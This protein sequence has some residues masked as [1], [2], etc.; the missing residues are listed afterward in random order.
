[1]PRFERNAWSLPN[2]RLALVLVT[3]SVSLTMSPVHTNAQQRPADTVMT[4]GYVY[5]V[6]ETHSV[7]EAIAIDQGRIVFVGNDGDARRYIGDGTEVVDLKDRMVLPGIHDGHLHPLGLG[8]TLSC[9]LNY[10]PL[11]MAEVRERIANCL[12]RTTRDPDD[13]LLQVYSWGP[14]LPSG[15]QYSKADLDLIPTE[16]P[17]A[18]RK[19]Y[20]HLSLVNSRALELAAITAETPD[21]P[22][23][24]IKRDAEGN[25]TGVLIDSAQRLGRLAASPT[26]EQNVRFARNVTAALIAQ[27]ATSFIDAAANESSIRAM[28]TLSDAGDL[29]LRANFAIR[30]SGRTEAHDPQAVLT[31]IRELRDSFSEPVISP[32]AGLHIGT[33]KLN[34]D[35]DFTY[36]SHSA[37]MLEPYL[38][39]VGT[40]ERPV[41]KPGPSR[42]PDPLYFPADD[43]LNPLVAALD[44]DGW[45]IHVHSN[46]DRATRRTLDAFEAAQHTN[47]T[48][49]PPHTRRHTITHLFLVDPTDWPRFGQMGVIASMAFQWHKRDN[50]NIHRVENYVG[51]ERFRRIYPARGLL[52]G[53]ALLAYG[54]DAPVDALD[55]WF[56]MEVAVTRT[57]EE[58]G[59]YAGS[60]NAAEYAITLEQA[61]EAF[62]INSAYQLN[63][64]HVTGSLEA[65]KFADL[66]VLDRN[67]F[68]VPIDEVSETKVIMTM[69]GGKV[70]YSTES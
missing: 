53:G 59:E 17:I 4:N 13:S 23:G 29:P 56:A 28:K 11:T 70:V 27:G 41:W 26:P 35:G 25:P 58:G 10:E 64:E 24:E 44:K 40:E 39:N 65:G 2:T 57:G 32:V 48:G 55:Y 43:V 47:R 15:A 42:G 18:M 69:V 45:Q 66:I 52:N 61:I 21:P 14:L 30:I 50:Y 38:V 51:P 12:E 62:T 1:M 31:R 6:D 33:V 63:Q 19:S 7:A 20:G 60:L 5:T 37:A 34:P 54:S 22:G 49:V 16:R 8:R 67:L 46:G 3:L 9:S 68:E 36:P